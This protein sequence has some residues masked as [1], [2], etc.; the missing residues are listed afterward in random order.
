MEAATVAVAVAAASSMDRPASG[1]E[2]NAARSSDFGGGK[3]KNGSASTRATMLAS[4]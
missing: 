4:T 3:A 2:A 1:S